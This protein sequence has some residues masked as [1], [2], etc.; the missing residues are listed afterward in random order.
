M[1]KRKLISLILSLA[2]MFS[3]IAI[4]VTAAAKPK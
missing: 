2:M 4:P 1:E 3:G